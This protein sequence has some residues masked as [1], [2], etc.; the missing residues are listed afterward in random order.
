[1]TSTKSRNGQ[2][3]FLSHVGGPLPLLGDP[4]HQEMV[5]CLQTIATRLRRPT[6]IVVISAHGEADHATRTSG[7]N[8]GLLYDYS[9]FPPESY[10]LAY[11]CRVL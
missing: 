8:P 11:P 1:M 10:Q 4:A 6:A 3:L 2:V 5:D 7:K 9:G